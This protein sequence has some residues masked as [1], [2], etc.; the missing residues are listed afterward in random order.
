MKNIEAIIKDVKTLTPVSQVA[1]K[2]MEIVEDPDGSMSDLSEIISYDTSITASLLKLANSAYF[3]LPGKFDTVH[4]AVVYLGME[5]V[6]DLVLIASCSKNFK[7]AQKGYA[8]EEGELWKLSVASALIAKDLAAKKNIAKKNFIFTG[9]LLKDIGKVILNQY[10]EDAFGKIL[11]IVCRQGKTFVEAEKMVIGIDHC[12]LG[13]IVAKTWNFPKGLME[14]IKNHHDPLKAETH[15]IET[16]I[17]YMSDMICMMM[18]TGV[19]SDALSYGFKKE[20]ATSLQLSEGDIEETILGF[21]DRIKKV[22]TLIG[23]N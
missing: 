10:V 18:G 5:Q 22:E 11:S 1:N 7:N 13:A 19:G 3:G 9:A 12:E 15:P 4:Q 6:I 21:S 8:L 20:V 17:V 14:I 16:G 2:V 23:I